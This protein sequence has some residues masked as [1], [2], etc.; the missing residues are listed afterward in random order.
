MHINFN[1][2]RYSF[3]D[4]CPLC[5][6][7][8]EVKKDDPQ[9][10]LMQWGYCDNQECEAERVVL[11][12]DEGSLRDAMIRE[13]EEILEARDAPFYTEEARDIVDA[14]QDLINSWIDGED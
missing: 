2:S 11:T 7:V 14:L 5:G 9:D 13:V 12:N 8:L 4:R 6:F 10:P 3:V 1:K